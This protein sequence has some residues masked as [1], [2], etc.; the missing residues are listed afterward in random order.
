MEN[1][2]SLSMVLIDKD[3]SGNEFDM[4][5][6]YFAEDLLPKMKRKQDEEE[7]ENIKEELK[8][9]NQISLPPFPKE[10]CGERMM[11]IYVDIYG[12]EFK[13]ELKLK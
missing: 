2:E 7:K 1:F 10:E 12:N 5:A 3:F 13:E 9:I 6:Y 4:D 8:H 11:V